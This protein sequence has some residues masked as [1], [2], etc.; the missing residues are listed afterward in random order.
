M[1][2]CPDCQLLRTP[3]SKHCP[4]CNRCVERFDHHCPW[5]N[6]CVGMGNHNSFLA[7]I[8]ILMIL[9]VCIFASSILTLVDE[10]HPNDIDRA[11]ACVMAD[12]C[13]G[14][15]IIWLRYAVLTFTVVVSLF[16]G[17][18]AG[19]LC[20][21]HIRNYTV[22]QTTNERFAKKSRTPSMASISSG[23]DE[24]RTSFTDTLMSKSKPT[25]RGCF[26]NCRRMCCEK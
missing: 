26:F 3:R 17:A 11:D 19:A 13:L 24:D 6:S 9:L 12:I 23:S 1:E 25:K 18:P 21:I 20:F 10:C 15:R 7:F 16:F 22:G 4:I 8:V 2:L 14:C 5:I